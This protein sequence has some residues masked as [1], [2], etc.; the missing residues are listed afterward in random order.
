MT[1]RWM[2]GAVLAAGLALA[3]CADSG[4]TPPNGSGGSPVTVSPS[5]EPTASPGPSGP[6]PS[7]P[8]PTHPGPTSPGNPSADPGTPTG[9]PRGGAAP[10]GT[11]TLSGTVRAGVEPNC[12]LLDN[13]LLVGGPR[14]VIAAGARVTVVGEVR[15]DLMTT[16]QQGI[17]FQVQSATRS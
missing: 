3:G 4:S 16:C 7:G 13:Y 11:T 14:D 5:P 12:L 8:G 9:P 10:S 15:A 6:D 17:P 1:T 2:V